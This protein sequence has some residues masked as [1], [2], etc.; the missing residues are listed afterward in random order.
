MHGSA[1]AQSTGVL[2]E[3][4]PPADAA[5]IRIIHLKQQEQVD[6]LVDG[7]IRLSGLKEGQFSD[8]MILRSGPHELQLQSHA[9]AKK[10]STT[11]IDVRPAQVLTLAFGN[12]QTQ[13][14]PQTFEDKISLNRMKANITVYHLAGTLGA[15]DIN[16]A[17]GKT[18]VFHAIPPLSSH[19]LAVNPI[20]VE[21]LA[22]PSARQ[23]NGSSDCSNPALQQARAALVLER[24]DNY[25]LLLSLDAHSALQARVS[26]NNVEA[27]AY[28]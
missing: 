25:S 26:K 12:L 5:Y 11:R 9:T 14:V 17:D 24:G 23:T 27:R 1:S 18:S 7:K 6:L 15:L 19:T 16:T 20:K 22:C 21:L 8:Y 28:K 2:Y 4:E 3:P 10:M 13:Q